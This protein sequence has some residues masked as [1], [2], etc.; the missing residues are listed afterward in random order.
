MLLQKEGEDSAI[1]TT[2]NTILNIGGGSGIGWGASGGVPPIAQRG[3]DCRTW[4]ENAGRSHGRGWAGLSGATCA[5]RYCRNGPGS[6]ARAA[7]SACGPPASND[8]SLPGDLAGGVELVQVQLT[9]P[10]GEK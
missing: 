5:W 6:L 4:S 1:K 2:N 10:S 8:D 9:R 7:G 3:G